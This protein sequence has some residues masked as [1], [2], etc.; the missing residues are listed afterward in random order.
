YAGD[1][2]LLLN[3]E[4]R[5]F[6]GRE[7][8]QLFAPG[9]AVFLDVGGA[10]RPGTA[11]ELRDLKVDVGA[12]LRFGIARTDSTVLRFDLAYRLNTDPT[13]RRGFVLSIGSS[14]AF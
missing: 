7:L 6:L 9:A 8:L 11:L 10:Q 4:D 13:G 12:G 1:K 14:Q 2:R 5:F 3:L